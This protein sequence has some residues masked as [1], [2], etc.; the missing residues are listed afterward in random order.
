MRTAAQAECLK[1][2]M[3]YWPEPICVVKAME[4]IRQNADFEVDSIF[5]M[6]LRQC[7]WFQK[8]IMAKLDERKGK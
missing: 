5:E 2:A 3:E 8:E 1:L 6:S 7:K 4:F